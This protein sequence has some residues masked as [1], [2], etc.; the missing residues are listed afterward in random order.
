MK[1]RFIVK[2]CWIYTSWF[3]LKPSKKGYFSEFKNKILNLYNTEYFGRN[4][5]H[6]NDTL[7]ND[8]NLEVSDSF[9]YSLLIRNYIESPYKYKTKLDYFFLSI[10]P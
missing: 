10:T 5:H 8:Y 4:F 2:W 1:D 7:E 3:K 6:F 9:I